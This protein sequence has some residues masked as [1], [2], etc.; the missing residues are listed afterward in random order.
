M[1]SDPIF[2]FGWLEEIYSLEHDVVLVHFVF[3]D[4]FLSKLI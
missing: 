3:Y 1:G 2:L 4:I